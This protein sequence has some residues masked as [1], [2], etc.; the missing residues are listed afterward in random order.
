MLEFE[1]KQ[2]PETILEVFSI[3][4]ESI[5]NAK[6]E[7]ILRQP[8]RLGN[9]ATEIGEWF[10]VSGDGSDLHH[11]WNGDLSRVHGIGYQMSGGRI[12]VN[13]DVGN[14]LG[15]RMTGGTIHTRGT[16]GHY[17]GAE[18]RGGLIQIQGN[19]GHGTG[20]AYDG[21][22]LGQNGGAILV[23][24]SA[25]QDVGRAMRRGLIGIGGKAQQRCGFT[26]RA[27][28]IMVCGGVTEQAG[29]E[30]V[31]GTIMLGG[32]PP[33][34]ATRFID[35][36]QHKFPVTNLITRYANQLGFSHIWDTEEW[37]LYHGD[38]LCGGRGELLTT[39]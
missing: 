29:L 23:Q 34:L 32:T 12:Q 28:T 22:R 18:M 4:P 1:L 35:A 8:I 36:G 25:G 3:T 11:I 26:M 5:Q 19:V 24:G 15:S 13:G 37:H 38:S 33:P 30:M 27:G 31:R 16:A 21:G 7:D 10:S 17:T 14:H 20:S 39:C 9:T 6:P 2:N